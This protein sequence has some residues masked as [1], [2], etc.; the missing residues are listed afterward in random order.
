M[1][2]G[3]DSKYQV[4]PESLDPSTLAA[5]CLHREEKEEFSRGGELIILTRRIYEY[6]GMDS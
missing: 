4:R 1:K 5:D 6:I 3:I 2:C